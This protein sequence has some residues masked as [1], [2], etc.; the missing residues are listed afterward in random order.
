MFTEYL[1][2]P[3]SGRFGEI[4]GARRKIDRWDRYAF[5]LRELTVVGT[6][7]LESLAPLETTGGVGIFRHDF[8]N[9]DVSVH[10]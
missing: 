8:Y 6:Q 3:L 1:Q 7:G 10:L 4:E 9:T 5:R 2:Q